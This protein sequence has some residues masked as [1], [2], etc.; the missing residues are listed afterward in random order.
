MPEALFRALLIG[1]PSYKDER[2]KDLPFIEDDLSELAGALR[3]VG[4]EAEVHDLTQTG[5][6]EIESAVE[7]FFQEAK[8]EETLLLF[9]SGHGIHHQD[10]DYLVPRGALT[11]VHDFPGKCVPIDFGQYAERSRAGDVAVFVDACR[12]GID[13]REKSV[14]NVMR[15]SDVRVRRVGDRHYCHVYACSKGEFAR[16]ATAGHSTFSLFSRALST[17]VAD[18]SGPSTLGELQER[19]QTVLDQL[20]SEH[21]CQRQQVRVRTE[22]NIDD[23]VLFARPDRGVPLDPGES[24]WTGLVKDHPAWTQVEDGPG[25]DV[26]K[27]AT[28]KLV[29]HLYAHAAADAKILENDPWSPLGLAERMTERVRWLLSKVLNP[30]KLALSPAEASLL[31]TIPFLYAAHRNRAAVRA[32]GAEPAELVRKAEPSPARKS[33]EQFFMGHARLV[34]RAG[35]AAAS[36]DTEGAAGIGWWLFHHWLMRQPLVP[37]DDALQDLLVPVAGLLDSTGTAEGRLITE[38]FDHEGLRT[39]LR[40]LQSTPDLAADRPV[41]QVAGSSDFEQTVRDQLVFALLTVAHRSAI[42]PLTLGDVVVDHVGISYSVTLP[43]LL[44]TLEKARWD[45][46]GRTRVLHAVCGH[47]AVG[48]ALRQQAVV[49]DGVLGAID[50]LA[51]TEPQLAALKDLPAHATADQ[52][53]PALT[54][55]GKRVYET[56]DLRFRLADDRIQEMLMGEELYGDPAL[57]VR[58]LYQNALDACR[59]REARW[60]YLRAKNPGFSAEWDGSIV[61]TQGEAGGR[62]Y[63]E[64]EDNGIG[65]GERELREV[66]SHAG[67]RFADL[68]EYRDEVARWRTENIELYPNSR[69]GIGVLSYF[70]IADDIQV[71]TCRLDH[72]GHPGQRLRVDIAGP[73]ALF[74]IQDLGRGHSAGTTVRLYL[75]DRDTA[76]VAKDLLRRLLWISDYRVVARDV[77]TGPDEKPLTW[78]PGVLSEVAPLGAEE[79]YSATAERNATAKVVATT[80]RTVWWCSTEGAVLAD[81]LWS[82]RSLFGAVVNLTGKNAPQLTVDRKRC[83]SLDTSHVQELLRDEIPSLLDSGDAVLTPE[84]LTQL[85][86]DH[87]YKLAEVVLA[88]AGARDHR[89]WGVHKYEGT[90]EAVGCFAADATIFDAYASADWP[91]PANSAPARLV[92][93]RV[94]SWAK[95]GAYPGVHVTA[96]ETVPVARPLDLALVQRGTVSLS[97]GGLG[98]VNNVVNNNDASVLRSVVRAKLRYGLPPAEAVRRLSALGYPLPEG[99]V[100]P[101]TAT[102]DDLQLLSQEGLMDRSF[103]TSGP[104]P[105]TLLLSAARKSG[106]RPAEVAARLASFGLKLPDWFVVPDRLPSG[107]LELHLENV[108]QVVPMAQLLLI[109]HTLRLPAEDLLEPLGELGY[110]LPSTALPVEAPDRTDLR[111]VSTDLDGMLPWLDADVPVPL[112]HVITAC[113][114]LSMRPQEVVERLKRLGFS[115][116]GAAEIQQHAHSAVDDLGILSK[117]GDEEAP[118]LSPGQRL[119]VRDVIVVAARTRRTPEEIVERWEAYGICEP[120]SIA[121][122]LKVERDD[123]VLLSRDLDRASPW[124]APE[125]PVQLGHVLGAAEITGRSADYVVTRLA[126]LGYKVP[127]STPVPSVPDPDDVTLLE[128]PSSGKEWIKADEPVGLAHIVRVAAATRKLPAEVAA[129]L[130]ELGYTLPAAVAFSRPPHV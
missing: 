73:G 43:D 103:K 83:L 51:E 127:D 120:G 42:D 53:Q 54:P 114:Q 87:D 7:I 121:T 1:V 27:E 81:G 24:P 21:E 11:R 12:E 123:V 39:L 104:V 50:V 28:M 122:P 31:V 94:L 101:E 71:T 3:G 77:S 52:V 66:F 82:G 76:P 13:V 37:Q 5:R 33:Y 8:P 57:A 69:F 29:D 109:A 97:H 126:D 102:A 14:S 74:R 75:R 113:A 38:V 45:R 6:D 46:H 112:G 78:S 72:E 118:W 90:V 60:K 100:V 89:P 64:C 99:V 61:F 80:R 93:W 23:F 68:P 40:A 26:L 88:E 84:W 79:V 56:T 32:F 15:W 128:V 58:E 85:A 2:I 22:S 107:D 105:P 98:H 47:P 16:Y 48:L 55:E 49:L 20:T 125:H 9:V 35:R 67:M 25:A 59:Y 30:Q 108:D 96:P 70:M 91:V 130:S 10:M 63:I 106:D 115:A 62:P 86:L 18:E 129:R 116:C 111:L 65:M 34:R 4:Y 124:L 36:G 44:V 19:L 95:A 41:R 110:R 17:L 92:E 119:D 117:H